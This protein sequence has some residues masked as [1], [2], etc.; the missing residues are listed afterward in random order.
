MSAVVLRMDATEAHDVHH[1]IAIAVQLL[2][3][4]GAQPGGAL[5]AESEERLARVARRLDHERHHA[6]ARTRGARR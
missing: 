4:V 6:T 1:A 2:E 3:Q 5:T